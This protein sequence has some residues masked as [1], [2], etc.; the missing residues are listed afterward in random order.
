MSLVSCML[1][2]SLSSA[3]VSTEFV[4]ALHL[5]RI[6]ETLVEMYLCIMTIARLGT[7]CTTQCIG[8]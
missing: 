4:I 8:V 5:M 3:L 6:A 1:L 7:P 2:R